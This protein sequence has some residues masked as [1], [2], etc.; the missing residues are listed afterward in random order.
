[1]NIDD[2][3]V[4]N[5]ILSE[6]DRI[7]WE[8]MGLTPDVQS[9]ENAALLTKV[10][11]SLF[12]IHFY[13]F[14]KFK[15]LNDNEIWKFKTKTILQM[16]TTA[17][18][19]TPTPVLNDPTKSA[20]NWLVKYLNS[21]EIAFEITTQ[22]SDRFTYT[23]E[24]A[25]RFGKILIVDDCNEIKPPLLSIITGIVQM[26]FNK[27]FLQVGNKL[28]DFN[29]NFKVI[30]SSR[31]TTNFTKKT[32]ILETFLA[33]IPFT[34]TVTG[35]TDQL[36]SKSIQVKQP[37]LETKRI[38]LLQNESDLLKKRE[39]LQEKLLLELSKSQGDI[40]KNEVRF[41]G[42]EISNV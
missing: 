31:G 37:E 3:E 15:F 28:V 13:I 42:T 8:S 5:K 30:L 12:I 27:K 38:S 18:G 17:F 6:Q 21:K 26:R 14:S 25:I 4:T 19:T 29:E 35:L 10:N 41:V 36:M 32:G 33:V 11:I 1:M 40:L 2:V 16:I 9:M 20:V 7:V 22:H 24:L 34:T 39:E 23:L